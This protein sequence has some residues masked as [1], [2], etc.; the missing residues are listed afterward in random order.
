LQRGQEARLIEEGITE[1]GGKLP[2][3]T[4]GG[5]LSKGH[6]IS[7]SG[8]AQVAELVWQLRARRTGVRSVMPR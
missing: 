1:I 7:A 8:I 2:V 5:L 4:N 3:N 6:P